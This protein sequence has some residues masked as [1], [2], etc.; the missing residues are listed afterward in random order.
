MWPLPSVSSRTVIAAAILSLAFAAGWSVNGW[1]LG[2]KVER[3]KNEHAT[4]L[5]KMQDAGAEV[6]RKRDAAT[7][8]ILEKYRADLLAANS[9][10]P[11]SVYRDPPDCL[12]ETASGTDG[13]GAPVSDR[14]DYGFE[15]RAARD[16]LIRC[17]ALIEVSK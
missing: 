14:R 4:E 3:L 1:R 16:A 2:S 11:R 10:K 15:L 9:R 8:P 17:N 12:S 13:P 7:K 6:V 5:R